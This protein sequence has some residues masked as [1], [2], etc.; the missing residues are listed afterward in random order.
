MASNLQSMASIL[1]AMASILL[2]WSSLVYKYSYR[3]EVHAQCFCHESLKAS[4]QFGRE[5]WKW[6]V[7]TNQCHL[8]FMPDGHESGIGGGHG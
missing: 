8:G 3:H 5:L 1:P 6:P 2:A 4:G 7:G